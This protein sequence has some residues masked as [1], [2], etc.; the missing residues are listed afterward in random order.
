LT[1]LDSAIA[2]A[3]ASGKRDGRIIVSADFGQ[4]VA[5]Q[6]NE[7]LQPVTVYGGLIERLPAAHHLREV[8]FESYLWGGDADPTSGQPCVIL[9][10]AAYSGAPR[11]YYVLTE[12]QALTSIW[13]SRQRKFWTEQEEQRRLEAKRRDDQFW[14]SEAGKLLQQKRLLEQLERQGKIPTTEPSPAVLLGTP[15]QS[16]GRE[17]S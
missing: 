17:N 2:R 4:L 10:L 15:K 1:A 5:F 6:V 14:S 11:P 9:G 3:I 8:A 16:N 12:A 13:S 7:W